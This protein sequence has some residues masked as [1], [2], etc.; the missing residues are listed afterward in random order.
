MEPHFQKVT[1]GIFVLL[2]N[3]SPLCSL[4]FYIK[5][6]LNWGWSYFEKGLQ[7]FYAG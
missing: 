7:I 1:C 2:I 6:V 3:L 5:E 4:V